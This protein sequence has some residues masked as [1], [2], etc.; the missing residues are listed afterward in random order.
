MIANEV[1]EHFREAGTWVDWDRTCDRFLHGDPE[2][3]VKGIATTWMATKKVIERAATRNLNL[4]VTHEPIFFESGPPYG[5]KGTT[6]GDNVIAQKKALLERS[7]I[8]V[9]R[10]H[11]VWD[12]FPDYGIPDAWA[13][14]LGFRTDPRPLESFHKVCLVDSMTL[15]ELGEHVLKKVKQLGEDWVLVFGDRNK[16]LRRMAVGTGAITRLSEMLEMD[17]DVALLTDDG[18]NTWIAGQFADD[19]GFPLLIVNHATSE[20]PGMRKM[21][22][23]LRGVFAALPVE[24]IDVEFPWGLV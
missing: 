15:E 16:A 17:I 8:T 20:K 9:M 2:I 13:E 6:Q 24:Y 1:M 19:S 14:F 21:A 11:D 23:Y 5:L 3:E 10:C 18:M 4:I 12:R 22:E 7:G